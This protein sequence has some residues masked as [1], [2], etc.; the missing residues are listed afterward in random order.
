[1]NITKHLNDIMSFA[2]RSLW[3]IPIMLMASCS[4]NDPQNI[5]P[6]FPGLDDFEGR[7]NEIIMFAETEEFTGD[8][9]EIKILAPDQSIISRKCSHHRKDGRSVFSLTTGLKEGDYRLLYIEYP[10]ESEVIASSEGKITTRQYGLGSTITV[11]NDGVEIKSLYNSQVGLSGAGTKDDPYIISSYDHLM[12]LAHKVNSDATNQL[13]SDDTYIRQ[14]V[15]IDMD[16]ACFFVDHRY[17]WEPIGNDVNLPFRGI[18]QGGRLENM[19]SLRDK[20]PAVGLFGYVHRAKIDGVTIY[21]GEFSG[22]FAV[23]AVAGASITEGAARDRAEITN[24][25]VVDSSITGSEG[26]L[27]IGGI[28]GVADMNSKLMLYECSNENTPVKGDYNVGGILGASSAYTLTSINNCRNSG[29]ISGG[30]SG[31]GGIVG[32]ADTLY[33]T[34][35]ENWAL[36]EGGLKYKDGDANNAAVGTGGIAGGA[37]MAFMTGCTNQSNV[38]GIEG[39]GGIL[40]S[41]RVNGDSKSGFVYNNALFRYCEN[42]GDVDGKRCVG[43]INGESQFGSY[44]VLNHGKVNGETYIGGIVGNTSIAVAHNAL[45]TGE[46]NGVDYVSG[47]VGKTTFGSLA[48]ND[49]YGKISGTGHHTGGIVGLAG[50]NAIIHYCG[51]HGDIHNTAGKHVGGLVGEVGDPREWTAWNIAECAVGAAEIV[52]S[53]AGPCIAVAEHAV[54]SVSHGVAIAIKISE[55]AFDMLLHATD[56]V[57]W[58]DTTYEMIASGETTEEVSEAIKAQTMECATAIDK[59]MDDIRK[60]PDSYPLNKAMAAN[61]LYDD[62]YRSKNSLLEWYAVTGNDEEF[63]EHINEVREERMEAEEKMHEASEIFHQCIGAVCLIAGTVAT[64]GATVATGGA[65]TAFMA[66]GMMV[67]IVGGVNAIEKSCMEFE[68]NAVVISQCIN[69][70]NIYGNSDSGSLVGSLQDSS[71]VRDCLNVG[72]G[73]GEER[74][75]LGHAGTWAGVQRCVNAGTNWKDGTLGSYTGACAVIRKDGV[76]SK[77]NPYDWNGYNAIYIDGSVLNETKYYKMVDNSWDIDSNENNIWG[78]PYAST[79]QLWYPVPRYSEIRRRSDK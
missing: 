9:C 21:R 51:N 60:S 27:A 68:S 38:K 15:D 45:N 1:M 25:K 74:I 8:A 62:N 19:W 20:S 29:K 43:G 56:L 13:F 11:N 44:S 14:V 23:G 7:I 59:E 72:N 67:G 77:D 75:F 69:S 66:A 42:F 79:D 39:V 2:K 48:L 30:F 4:D 28:V 12:T 37:G 76:G 16:D 70:G 32:T 50:N 36:I 33:V 65:A 78:T 24:C 71:I 34:S 73:T 46:V 54:S 55:F 18:Y 47:I 6:T 17:G 3:V 41:N 61:P 22:N 53:L 49:N 52:F 26:S 64:I 5:E 10:A 35:C 31:A 63:N 57:L 58:S 40:G